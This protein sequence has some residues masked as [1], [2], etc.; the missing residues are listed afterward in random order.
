MC[1]TLIATAESTR[2]GVSIFAKNS[3]REPNE[4]H[5]VVC[6]PAKDHSAESLA[7][8]TYVEIPQVKHTFAILLAKPFWIWGAEMGVNEHGLAIGNE[9]IFTKVP[10]IKK[11]LLGMDLLRLGLERASTARDGVIVITNLLAD[12][13]QGG[14]A[15]LAH[16]S[17]YH[18]SFILADPKEAW[19]LE[20]AGREWA[21]K[22]IKGV[23]S[24]SNGLTIENDWDI[25]S[26]GLVSYAIQMGWCRNE[27]DFNFARCYSDFLYTRFSDCRKRRSRSLDLLN[28]KRGE[29]TIELMMAILRDH[30]QADGSQ[31]SADESLS[32]ADI[33]MH[34]GFGP[35]RISQTTGSMVSYLSVN[36]PLHFVTGTAAPCTSVFKPVWIDAFSP[37]LS[38]SLKSSL[39]PAPDEI[40]DEDSLFWQHEIFHRTL[41]RDHDNLIQTFASK[42]D[43]LEREFIGEACQARGESRESRAELTAKCFTRADL[44]EQEWLQE[45]RKSKANENWLHK[46]AWNKFNIE[47]RIPKG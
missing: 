2:D 3:D 17:Y 24:I 4:A 28:A 46:A 19:V 9:A 32:G 22:Q 16:P 39:G 11:G 38:S 43:T 30:G 15:G 7:K 47:A 42:R 45:I 35:I 23:Y 10:Y 5:H 34:A 29:I 18:N 27:S 31:R 44:A 14:N 36:N 20:T 41:L 8:C 13:G 33:C 26:P 12:F 1:D 21:A 40:F 25:A 6:F 37:T